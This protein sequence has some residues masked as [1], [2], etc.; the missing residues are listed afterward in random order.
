MDA[1][2]AEDLH[3][4]YKTVQALDGVSFAVRE[5]EVFGLLGPNGAGKSTTVRVLATLSQPDS[6]RALVAG[7]D[8]VR[9]PNRVR[10]AIGYI[11]Q[12]SGVDWEATG[13]ENLMLQGRIHGMSGTELRKRVDELLE[14]MGLQDAA[15]R[16]ARGY[17]GGMKRRLDIATGL[18][19]RPRV[20]FL[21]EPTTGL[22][23]EARAAMWVEVERLAEQES[24]TILLTTHYLEEAD[25]LAERVAIVSRGKVVV[26]GTPAELKAGLRGELV[27]VELADLNGRT[28]EAVQVVHLVEGA[29]EVVAEGQQVRA[30]VPSGALAIPLILSALED[31]GFPVASV[32]TARPSL[33]DV[34]LHYTGR[35]FSADDEE[36]KR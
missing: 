14:L 22:D 10:R 2:V 19:H 35:D 6:G 23:P 3:K 16:Q 27:T 29:T 30:R 12:D 11:A 13:R 4:R 33:D 15:D 26:E 31:G 25:R 17:S 9:H 1:I 36:G 18:V 20:L 21:D 8:V 32:T 28:S 34:Y 5:G 24:L 7:E